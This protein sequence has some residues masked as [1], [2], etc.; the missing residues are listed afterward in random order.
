MWSFYSRY[1]DVCLIFFLFKGTKFNVDH[2]LLAVQEKNKF[3]L[4][5]FKPESEENQQGCTSDGRRAI[6]NV[7]SSPILAPFL[8][9]ILS[10]QGS[11]YN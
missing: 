3:Y 2:D 9:L 1:S 6:G 8:I 4:L 10:F 7:L 5:I 11:S